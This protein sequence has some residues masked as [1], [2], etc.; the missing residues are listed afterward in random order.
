VENLQYFKF[1][2]LTYLIPYSIR[3]Q[4]TGFPPTDLSQFG[5][6][7]L[8]YYEQGVNYAGNIITAFISLA[9]VLLTNFVVY[10]LLRLI[11][12]KLPQLLAKKIH[13]RKIITL[14]D[15]FDQ[16]IFPVFFFAMN[17]LEYVL[18]HSKLYWIYAFA[19]VSAFAAVA[20]PFMVVLYIYNHRHNQEKVEVFEDL[21]QDNTMGQSVTYIYYIFNYYRKIFFALCLTDTLP[22][23]VQVYLLICLN[24]GHL[25]FQLYLVSAK[26]F[27]SKSKVIVR[28][29]NSLCIIA[30]EILIIVYN[31]NWYDTATMINIGMS[32]FYLSIITALL[33]IIDAGIKLFDTIMQEVKTKRVIPGSEDLFKQNPVLKEFSKQFICKLG[34]DLKPRD[35][36]EVKFR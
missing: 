19:A 35:P 26:T 3:S 24:T 29:I 2:D 6:P 34:D 4:I 7:K 8:I 30:V 32:C 5:S 11:P 25:A 36:K 23:L 28:L 14:H 17:N 10:L 20:A 18:Y 1:M 15:S 16:L 22:G 33:N 13:R 9:F 27:K 21:M 31:L 12:F